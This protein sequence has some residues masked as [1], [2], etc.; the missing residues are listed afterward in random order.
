MEIKSKFL[1]SKGVALAFAMLLGGSP[2]VLLYA[3]D[4]VEESLMVAQAGRTIKGLVTDANGEPLI[5]CNV[6]VVG[7]NAGVI[8]DID[9]RFA[10]N[11]PADAKQIRITYIGYADQI[12]NFDLSHNFT[13]GERSFVNTLVLNYVSDKIYT[14]G[15]Q[16]YQDIME[17]GV[18]T[19][20]FVS[21]AKLNKHL[22]LNLK[23]RNLL[24]PSYKLSRKA[25]ENGEKVILNDYKK[26]INISLG[27]SCTF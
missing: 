2:G 25:N 22:S 15:T 14:I 4:S 6:V 8:T 27:V 5:G 1:C 18:L 3:N 10:L 11:V 9:G 16:G 12:V 26:G 7:S 23:A 20:D 19:L 13:K 24:N 17:Q 21:Q